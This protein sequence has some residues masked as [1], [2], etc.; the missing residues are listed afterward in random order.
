MNTKPATT[1]ALSAS[2]LLGG[3]NQN[4]LQFYTGSITASA[5]QIG[6]WFNALSTAAA[7][8]ASGISRI[9]NNPITNNLTTNCGLL[10][11]FGY[12]GGTGF[13]NITTSQQSI[14]W[15]ISVTGAN[16]NR[17]GYLDNYITKFGYRK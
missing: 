9:N 14:T 10:T 16:G 12:N 13:I 2:S 17:D 6:P 11:N 3:L 1:M 8:S 15:N 7:I 5:V 4:S